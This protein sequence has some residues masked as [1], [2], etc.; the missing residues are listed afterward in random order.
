MKTITLPLYQIDAFTCKVFGGNPAAVVPLES[1][2]DD[3][4]MQRIAA[5]NNLSETAFLVKEEEHYRIRWFTPTSEVDLCGHATLASA[6][7]LFNIL[8]VKAPVIVFDSRSGLLHVS[9]EE[10][11]LVMDFPA[12]TPSPC[13]TPEAVIKAFAMAPVACYK[14]MDYIA[15]FENE[16]DILHVTPD[17]TALKALD[18][19]GVIITAKSTQYDF[20]CR[21]FA[22]NFGI[23]EDPVTGSAFTQLVPYWSRVL[24]KEHFY[25]AQVSKRGGEV[26]CDLEGERVNI[27]GEAALYL[28]GTI[29]VNI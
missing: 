4:L 21:F 17:V 29:E 10:E 6:Y 3:A 9:R 24:G 1:W 18:L 14:A 16:A 7:V 19:R 11:R 27:A 25:A 13:E 12:Q 26:W 23:D 8:G 2:L 20:T 5:E 15:V 28:K 22:P